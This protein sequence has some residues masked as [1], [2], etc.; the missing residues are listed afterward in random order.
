MLMTSFLAD[1][2]VD[3]RQA[4]I[5]RQT[6]PTSRGVGFFRLQ[7]PVP[8]LV[9]ILTILIIGSSPTKAEPLSGRVVDAETGTGL[10]DVLI[11]TLGG[12]SLSDS[13]GIFGLPNRAESVR[14]SRVGYRDLLLHPPYPNAL[15]VRLV[16]NPIPLSPVDVTAPT[17]PSEPLPEPA[18]TTVI[19]RS[20]F[21]QQTTT[22][23][24]VLDR[25][26]GIQVQSLGGVGTVSTVSVRGAS[27]D[28]I[29]VYLDDIL[30]NAAIGGGVNLANLPLS[31]VRRIEINR[32]SGQTGNGVGGTVHIR[33][34]KQDS[35]KTEASASWGSFDTRSINLFTSQSAGR[36]R[37]LVVA[38]Y[39]SSDNDF[40]FLDDN[41]TEYNANDD[42]FADRQN[43]DVRNANFLGKV[44][45]NADTPFVLSA[46]Q[47]LHAKR[48][49]IPGISNN[50]STAAHLRSIRSSTQITAEHRSLGQTGHT[51]HTLYFSHTGETFRDTLGEVGVGRQDNTYRT[52]VAGLR[53]RSGLVFANQHVLLLQSD[54][55]RETYDPT[56][57]IQLITP[58]FASRRWTWQA[59]PRLE[60]SFLDSQ[61]HWSIAL[62]L[63]R[64]LSSFE[65]RNPFAF[66]PQAPESKSS[67]NL[68]GW[69][70]G[71]R[72][73]MS[74]GLSFKANAAR[75]ERA[76]SFHELFGDRGGV[77]GNTS[78]DPERGHTWDAGILLGHRD[79]AF[80]AVYFYQRY[81]GL[82]QFA[83][84][85]QATSRPVNVGKARAF[86]VE[87]SASLGVSDQLL[88]SANYTFLHTEDRSAIPHLQGN[89]LPGRP[90]H[91]AS[92]RPEARFGRMTATYV[93]AFEDGNV[94]DQ[95]NR[96]HLPSRHLHNI[97]LR[98][99]VGLNTRVG[100]DATNLSNA[101]VFDLWGY[102]LPGRAFGVSLTQ[103]WE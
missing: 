6:N 69:H 103:Q 46:S 78:L 68:Y 23:P 27:S 80:E 93:Y 3:V 38:D 84:T 54:I 88:L 28:Q 35:G 25:S 87:T 71:L 12:S 45:F 16:P 37:Y 73:R 47:S 8:Q 33:T 92:V 18:F 31:N 59:R 89:S 2:E 36:A 64:I 91:K 79:V 57:N 20:A 10:S 42:R 98:V 62:D 66:S 13:S 43:N 24:E 96:R 32:G 97:S 53:S 82:I 95:A 14:L 85:S 58:L 75:S 77:L 101:R 86:G 21:D 15:I 19:E 39:A 65:G 76:P 56:A 94:L 11:R 34:R 72:I 61:I 22:L 17:P 67:R 50:Q 51:K 29:E 99:R 100:I 60:L 48:Q 5:H 9:Y 26:A 83:Q 40:G 44:V 41:G 70:T 102:P 81:D 49:G 63:R 55:R 30:L 7:V 4:Y 74:D 1:R 52:R 90:R